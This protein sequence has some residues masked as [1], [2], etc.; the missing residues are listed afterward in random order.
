MSHV[1]PGAVRAGIGLAGRSRR[2]SDELVGPGLLLVVSGPSG[3]GKD[4]MVRLL[5]ARMP[6]MRYSVSATT[7]APRPTEVEGRDYYFMEREAFEERAR[8]GEFLEW[9]EYAGNLYGTPKAFV[10]RTLADGHDLLLKPEV[11]GALAVKRAYDRAVLV[12]IVPGEMA[13]LHARLAERN[14]ESTDEIARR[15]ATARDELTFI[16]NFDY[17][18]VNDEAAPDGQNVPAVADLKAIVD[19][20]RLRIHHYDERILRKFEHL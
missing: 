4:T 19:A 14:T 10:E 15:L 2:E 5:L 17:L 6:A 16:R 8:R 13:H 1:R 9:R 7:R 12:F 20:E 11:N 18:V 3:A